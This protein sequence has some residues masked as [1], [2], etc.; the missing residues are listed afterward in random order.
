MRWS[1]PHQQIGQV[2]NS[3]CRIVRSKATKVPDIAGQGIA[4]PI[5][6]ILSLSMMLRL[7]LGLDEEADAVEKAVEGGL[8]E[9]YRTPDIA[10][11]SGSVVKTA[12]MG[13]VIA[14]RV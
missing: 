6:T 10:G 1:R 2:H 7:S 8:A 13:G 5:G 4:N 14:G 3:P 12:E 9:G 11:D